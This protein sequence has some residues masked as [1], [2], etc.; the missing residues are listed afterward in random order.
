MFFKWFYNDFMKKDETLSEQ[1]RSRLQ[2]F[3]SWW[4]ATN[5]T[6]RLSFCESNRCFILLFKFV[7]N[8][9]KAL[10]IGSLETR[11]HRRTLLHVH[12]S[13]SRRAAGQATDWDGRRGGLTMGVLYLWITT[14]LVSGTMPVQET[15][16]T[17]QRQQ[18]HKQVTVRELGGG[19]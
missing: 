2:S 18:E 3:K 12:W 11:L 19:V 4:A 7:H 10:V 6:N 16:Q 8:F 13:D 15:K 5:S 14:S 17:I 9:K 1:V